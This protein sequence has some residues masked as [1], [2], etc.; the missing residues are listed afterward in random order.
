MEAADGVPRALGETLMSVQRAL[1]D[2]GVMFVENGASSPNGGV[3]VR[4]RNEVVRARTGTM[5]A[6]DSLAT[7]VDHL[8][9]GE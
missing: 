2:A 1:E 3:G 4:F 6:G 5:R 8:K 9:D 7:F